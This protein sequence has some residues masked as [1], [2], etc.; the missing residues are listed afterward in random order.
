MDEEV[1]ALL[2]Q[3]PGVHPFLRKYMKKLAQRLG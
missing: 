2:E 1:L 3:L